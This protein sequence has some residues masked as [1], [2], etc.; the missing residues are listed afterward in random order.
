MTAAPN[1][2]SP[3]TARW[4]AEGYIADQVAAEGRYA[5]MP[6]R[7]AAQQNAAHAARLRHAGQRIAE[8]Q[9]DSETIALTGIRQRQLR[10]LRR[11]CETAS[12]K[13]PP[14]TA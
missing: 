12:A 3:E 13:A 4:T 5:R 14:L 6:A 8:G 1:S 9:D 7:Q 11:I 2:T 10:Q